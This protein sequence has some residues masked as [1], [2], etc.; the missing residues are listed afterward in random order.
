LQL[1]FDLWGGC[2]ASYIAPDPSVTGIRYSPNPVN[3]FLQL[4]SFRKI[5][6]LEIINTK[7]MMINKVSGFSSLNN[8][9]DFR[10]Y[11]PGIYFIRIT[12]QDDSIIY[13]KVVKTA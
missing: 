1:M 3:D 12:Q 11:Y 8:T 5:K 2:T 13:L 7:G 4:E 6:S 9:I 10:N